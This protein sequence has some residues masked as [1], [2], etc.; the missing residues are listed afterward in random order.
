VEHFWDSPYRGPYGCTYAI[1]AVASCSRT[2][3]PGCSTSPT[4]Q[5]YTSAFLFTWMVQNEGLPVWLSFV[6]SVVILAPGLGWLR[7][8]LVPQDRPHQHTASWSPDQP[9][10]GSLPCW[11]WSSGAPISTTRRAS[12]ST[13][14]R[15]LPGGRTPSTDLRDHGGPDGGDPGGAGGPDAPDQPGTADAG[16]V[17]SRRS[18]SSTG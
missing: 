6:L 12:C 9:V 14:H 16:A 8:V 2:R 5:A 18:S 17:E 15:V 11:R 3:P 1:V 7:P 10:R 4:G 13:R